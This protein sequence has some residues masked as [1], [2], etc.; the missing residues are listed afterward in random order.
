MINGW[1]QYI[2]S[3]KVHVLDKQ[4]YLEFKPD[5]ELF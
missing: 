1:Y 4:I 5:V 2:T 3:I